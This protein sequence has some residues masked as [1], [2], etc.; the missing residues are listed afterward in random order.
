MSAKIYDI[1]HSYIGE[2]QN[3]GTVATYSNSYVGK[4]DRDERVY[5]YC[6]KFMGY[7]DRNGRIY[8][9]SYGY[10][11]RIE[12][13]WVYDTSEQMVAQIDGSPRRMAAAAYM[14]L[15]R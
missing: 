8:D 14:L 2:V 9:D 5:D 1:S 4:V 7:V 12:N 3:D 10:M 15:L 13:E 11:G 6:S